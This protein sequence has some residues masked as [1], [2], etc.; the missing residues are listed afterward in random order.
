MTVASLRG[1]ALC[2]NAS[3]AEQIIDC[4]HPVNYP[5]A[6]LSAFLKAA[7][8]ASSSTCFHVRV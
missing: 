7:K 3:E 1:D 5:P 6:A 8:A 2:L 4:C